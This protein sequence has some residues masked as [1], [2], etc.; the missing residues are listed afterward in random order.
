MVH[1]IYLYAR[2][3]EFSFL[4]HYRSADKFNYLEYSD[5]LFLRYIRSVSFCQVG[6]SGYRENHSEMVVIEPMLTT[7]NK[8]CVTIRLERDRHRTLPIGFMTA[9]SDIISE[10]RSEYV[11]LQ[12]G[13]IRN[14]EHRSDET[15]YIPLQHDPRRLFDYET[16]EVW[17]TSNFVTISVDMV[18][19]K[20]SIT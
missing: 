19:R 1:L 13:S 12:D 3:F 2:R 9:A 4:N 20:A 15:F 17:S 11:L 10:Q 6:Y 14:D 16:E 7:K 18:K 8:D 5:Y